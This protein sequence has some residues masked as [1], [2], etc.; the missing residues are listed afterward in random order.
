MPRPATNAASRIPCRSIPLLEWRKTNAFSGLFTGRAVVVVPAVVAPVA[1]ARAFARFVVVVGRAARPTRRA[2]AG[3]SRPTR[4]GLVA[5]APAVGELD[6][7]G[8]ADVGGGSGAPVG[9][10]TV[11]GGTEGGGVVPGGITGTVVGGSVVGGSVVGTGVV[12]GTVVGGKVV[13]G[14]VV[15]GEVVGGTVGG[16]SVGGGNVTGIVIGMVIGTVIGSAAAARACS[17]TRAVHAK[18]R[19]GFRETMAASRGKRTRSC[20]PA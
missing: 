1:R 4:A 13:G 18:K 17:V 3:A 10:A 7:G 2:L 19:A 15:G 12:T 14:T 20:R 6:E 5:V 9:G 11:D 16:G 8:R